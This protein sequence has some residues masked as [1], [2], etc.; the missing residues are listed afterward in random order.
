R[1]YIRVLHK[2]LKLLLGLDPDYRRR[3][4]APSSGAK[5]E[6]G[7]FS[8][9]YGYEGVNEAQGRGTLHFHVTIH[10]NYS[11]ELIQSQLYDEDVMRHIC[12]ILDD[13]ACCHL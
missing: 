10:N 8:I 12:S 1:F 13:F 6:K 4:S 11:P 7:I 3:K 5:K 9:V 2:L